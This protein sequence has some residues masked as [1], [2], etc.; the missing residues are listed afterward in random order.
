[1]LRTRR[2]ILCFLRTL[3]APPSGQPEL[4][5]TGNPHHEDDKRSDNRRGKKCHHQ[6]EV[7]ACSEE[8]DLN[9]LSVLNNKYDQCHPKQRRNSHGRPCAADT[10]VADASDDRLSWLWLPYLLLSSGGCLWYFPSRGL[11][12][13]I[14]RSGLRT[15]CA[16][17]EPQ[18][19]RLRAR[20]PN[21]LASARLLATGDR[22]PL[23]GERTHTPRS[24][25]QPP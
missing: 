4:S 1:M 3:R 25:F 17:I 18:V 13:L 7:P 11:F 14:H 21:H 6:G 15:P 19:D 20:K 23:P 10:R 12:S 22:V 2:I 9:L 8:L 5:N 16:R 24:E